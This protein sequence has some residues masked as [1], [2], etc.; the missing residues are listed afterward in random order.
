MK[1]ANPPKQGAFTL[2]ELLV[3][4]AIIGVLIA[5]L[6]PAVQKV[7][8]AVQRSQCSNNLRQLAV[9]AH[10]YH[11]A[12]G[13]FPSGLNVPIEEP[14]YRPAGC[15]YLTDAA[16][17]SGKVGPAPVYRQFISWPEALMPYYEQDNLQKMLD[18]SGDQFVNC[19]GTD[20]PGA[21]VIKLL[22]CPVDRLERFVFGYSNVDT[23][24]NFF[25][26][27]SYCGNAGI[28]SFPVDATL[29]SDGV[30]YFNSTVR[31]TDIT[32]GTSNTFLFGERY[33]YDPIWASMSSRGG[34]AWS[35][36]NSSQDVLL[37]TPVPINYQMDRNTVQEQNW[38]LCAFGSGH[39]GGAN[40][41]M[42]DGSVRFFRLTGMGDLPVL[43]AL[44]TRSGGEVVNEP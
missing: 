24:P 3:V 26:I 14:G 16:V 39:F 18:F 29:T 10:N 35:E 36:Y 20:S 37:S 30:L 6:L 7:R 43:Q 31:L 8:A 23:G 21:Q 38:R 32:D 25:G 42:S 28:S 44:S 17:T 5:L 33:H 34:W 22:I 40:F 13:R 41:A 4:V 27:N 15:F 9:A 12:H 11:D 19:M 2:I 1:R